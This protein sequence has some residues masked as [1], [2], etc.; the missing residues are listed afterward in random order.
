MSSAASPPPPSPYVPLFASP[1]R[2][3][4]AGMTAVRAALKDAAT[5]AAAAYAVLEVRAD[6]QLLARGVADERGEVAAVLAYPEVSA[7]PPWSPPGVPTP[8]LRLADQSWT[9]DVTVR[10]RRNLPRV[11]P[12]PAQPAVPDLC[13]VIQQPVATVATSSPPATLG[14]LVLRYGEELMLAAEAGGELLIGPA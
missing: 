12:D 14:E 6:G 8:R 10:Y 11:R 13:D 1:S 4:P 9:I 5:G 2:P 3:V 7:L